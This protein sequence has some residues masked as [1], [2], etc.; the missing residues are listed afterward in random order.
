M[1]K[2]TTKI[3]AA[4]MVGGLLSFGLTK[5]IQPETPQHLSQSENSTTSEHQSEIISQVNYATPILSPAFESDV[6][7]TN[8]AEKTVNSV[9]HVTTQYEMI[10]SRD[11]F[12]EFFGG[13]APSTQI[14]T[15]SG[16]IISNDGYIV[17]NNHVV[18]QADKIEITLNNERTFTAKVIGTDPN[19]DLALIKIDEKDLPFVNFGNSDDV[20]IGEWVLAVGN[21]FN[22]TSTVTAGIVSA[23][24]RN[25]NILQRSSGAKDFP[26]ESFIQTDAAVNPGNSGGALVSASGNLIGINTAIASQTGSYTGYSFAIPSNI[27]KK[28]TE[29]LLE[30]G[31]VQ[32]AF[33]GVS[34]QNVNQQVANEYDLPNLKGV[35]VNGITKDGAA[36]SA[37]IQVN[38][39]ILKVG[40]IEVNDVPELQEQIGSFRPGEEASITIRR[41]SEIKALTVVLRNKEGS[42]SAI[43]KEDVSKLTVLGATFK[44]L[45]PQELKDLRIE[46]G[47]KISSITSGKLR[48][49]GITEGF[50]ITK[51][52]KKI[53]SSPEA[54]VSF[55]KTKKGGVL[56]EGIYPNGTKGYFGFGL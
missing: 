3:I 2:S 56:V 26:L 47:V 4:G 35:M 22:L 24:A 16:V 52:D 45:S 21:P 29:D 19:T 28:V 42:T 34:I 32:R 27:V 30:Y 5:T 13:G 55:F 50:V 1:I 33:I 20:K 40:S 46:K 12:A 49:A 41:G 7:F 6:S 10:G 25:I 54:V 31:I 36:K 18:D 17:T 11:P 37:G 51:I 39:V 44:S 23:K 43:K 14:A 53:V 48:N 38:D 15:G 9:V 8:A